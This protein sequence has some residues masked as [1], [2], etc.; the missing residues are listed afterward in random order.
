MDQHARDVT[1]AQDAGLNAPPALEGAESA[2][3]L[4]AAQAD[5]AAAGAQGI[6]HSEPAKGTGTLEAASADGQPRFGPLRLLKVLGPG[7][8]TGASDDDP[9]GI[10]TY[11]VAGASLGFAPL[12]MAPFTFPLMAAIQYMCAKVGMVSGRGLAGIL[13]QHYSRGVLYPAVL[14]LV[15]A[16]TINAGADIGAIAAAINLLVP[17]PISLMI[18]PITAAILALQVWGSYRL[19]AR[20][21]KWLTLALFAYVAATFFARPAWGEVLHA[22]LVPTLRLDR[23]FVATVVAILGTTISPYLFFWQ[24]SDEVEEEVSAGR[25]TL[26]Q[27]KGATRAELTY[28]RWDVLAGMLVS[29]LVMY[30]IILATAA[31][32][33]KAGK[34]DIQSATDA[35]QA[36]RP[37]AGN[38]AAVLLAVGLIGSGVLAVPILTGSGAYAVAESFGWKY[39]LDKQPRRA[40]QFYGVIAASTAVAMLINFIGLNPIQALVWAAI[41]NGLLAPPLLVVILLVANNRRIMGARRNGRLVNVLG[42][43]TAALMAGAAIVLLITL[44]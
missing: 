19:I 34:T 44:L 36:L 8:I 32:L 2:E 3:G 12:W 31:T 14:A 33:F 39:G 24:A 38:A 43:I 40:K 15:I 13:R 27:R 23:T 18:V 30:F 35:A 16:N 6:P 28:A 26:R 20:V 21:F 42:A 11:S 29:N 37:L 25:T 7:F 5:A 1:E 41:L 9:S 10:G 4:V 22:T 17:V